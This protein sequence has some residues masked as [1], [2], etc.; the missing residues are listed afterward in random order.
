MCVSDRL[1]VFHVCVLY[2]VP[3][4]LCCPI[5]PRT[6]APGG[7][8]LVLCGPFCAHFELWLTP[9]SLLS[10]PVDMLFQWPSSTATSSGGCALCCTN[11]IPAVVAWPAPN[12]VA[13]CIVCVPALACVPMCGLIITAA[14]L[15]NLSCVVWFPSLYSY[16]CVVCGVADIILPWPCVWLF[17]FS[18]EDDG[19]ERK[20]KEGKKKT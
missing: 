14:L 16:S 20:K 7:G 12:C 4:G 19:R 10:I 18:P 1:C 6:V 13:V 9:D 11:P 2:C 5:I 8:S 17:F 3:C 15:T